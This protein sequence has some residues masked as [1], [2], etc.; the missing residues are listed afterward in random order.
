MEKNDSPN[1]NTTP[2]FNRNQALSVFFKPFKKIRQAWEK[3][4]KDIIFNRKTRQEETEY[5]NFMRF[6]FK[7]SDT[8]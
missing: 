8:S 6:F 4:Q 3:E 1:K 7:S 5:F 2:V